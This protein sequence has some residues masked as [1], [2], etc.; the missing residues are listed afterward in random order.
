MK[1][2]SFKI[3]II[4]ISIVFGSTNFVLS[5]GSGGVNI[6]LNNSNMGVVDLYNNLAW[7]N[8]IITDRPLASTSYIGSP[9]I[10]TEWKLADIIVADS[11]GVIANMPVR[12]DVQENLVEINHENVVKVLKAEKV[13]SLS[14]KT[15]ED[16]FV[17]NKTLGIEEPVGFFKVIYSKKSSLLCHYYTKLIRSTYNPVLD[18]GVKDNKLVI[19][20][21][22]YIMQ[23]Q[24]LIKLEKSNRK[25]IK[26]FNGQENVVNYI[27]DQHLNP[28][29]LSDLVK[30]VN[31]IDSQN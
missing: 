31:F 12:I 11:K 28:K 16:V 26:Q 23:D 24:K 29:L 25:L 19:E 21:T 14:F 8:V 5:Q 22:Y 7:Q 13:Y 6:T 17:S 9:F 20:E 3:L 18:A 4:G 1:N 15:D 2:F 10:N 27:K 30:L